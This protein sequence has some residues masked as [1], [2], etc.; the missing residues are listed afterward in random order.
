[1]PELLE[2]YRYDGLKGRSTRE[3]FGALGIR[4][5]NALAFLT[6]T[7]QQVYRNLLLSG[8][9]EL[10]P[11]ARQL[12]DVF[13]AIGSAMFVVTSGSRASIMPAL[14]STGVE[15][16]FR[17]VITADD[18]RAGKPASEPY[19]CCVQRYGLDPHACIV[20]ED[21]MSG[22]VAARRAGMPVIGVHDSGIA[23]WVDVFFS[24]LWDFER[25]VCS[26]GDRRSI[27]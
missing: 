12:L 3:A 1:M 11:G 6:L 2:H 4:D 24:S 25:W 9:L 10:L 22:V 5:R 23:A 21:A 8:G 16:V 18:V 7:K 17:G 15:H 19:L 14:H 27:S 20:I 13:A 26:T